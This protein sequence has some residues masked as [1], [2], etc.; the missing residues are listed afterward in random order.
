MT[1]LKTLWNAAKKE[2]PKLLLQGAV[3]ALGFLLA[4]SINGW[5]EQQKEINTYHSMLSAVR[6]EA[7]ANQAIV[8]TSYKNYFLAGMVIKEFRYSTA[9]QMLG[10]PLFMKY[11]ATADIQLLNDYVDHLSLANG[12]R[13]VAETLMLQQPATPDAVLN[14]SGWLQSVEGSWADLLP[15]VQKDV[16]AAAKLKD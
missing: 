16:E 1:P 15:A 5:V 3:S 9:T 13:Q 6:T 8:N 11:A 12:Y 14:P 10:N 2:L 7:S 4:L